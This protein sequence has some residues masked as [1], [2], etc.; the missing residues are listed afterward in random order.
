MCQAVVA[1]TLIPALER[2]RQADLFLSSRPIRST[3][4]VPGQPGLHREPCLEKKTRQNKTKINNVF[5]VCS[6]KVLSV[7]KENK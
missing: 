3:E 7:K 6:V 1:H 5:K 4:R 2:Q